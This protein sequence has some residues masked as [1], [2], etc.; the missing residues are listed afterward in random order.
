MY[1]NLKQ[2]A[3]V[4][5]YGLLI[6]CTVF[7]NWAMHVKPK[8]QKP[9]YVIAVSNPKLANDIESLRKNLGTYFFAPCKSDRFGRL[10][11]YH[12][13]K[14]SG[15]TYIPAKNKLHISLKAIPAARYNPAMVTN[16]QQAHQQGLLGVPKAFRVK[17]LEVFWVPQNPGVMFIVARTASSDW[18]AKNKGH[19]FFY[20]LAQMIDVIIDIPNGFSFKAHMTVGK[21]TGKNFT[22]ADAQHLQHLLD[23]YHATRWPKNLYPVTGVLMSAPTGQ[24]WRIC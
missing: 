11:K 15:A 9:Y 6:S 16:L 23:K 18:C 10:H 12:L 22:Q 14:A 3:K 5:S 19:H 1:A 7:Q 20:N 13:S 8:K 17:R 24:T 4:L 2:F 21:I